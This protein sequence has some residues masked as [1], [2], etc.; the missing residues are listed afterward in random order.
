LLRREACTLTLLLLTASYEQSS[1]DW[2]FF[3]SHWKVIL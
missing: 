3:C 2:R 1:A